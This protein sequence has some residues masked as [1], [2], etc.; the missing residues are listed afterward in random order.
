[1]FGFLYLIDLDAGF[2]DSGHAGM[3]DPVLALQWVRD[4]IKEFGGDLKH[5]LI[6]GQSGDGAKC[7][8]LT[9]RSAARGRPSSVISMRGQQLSALRREA[10]TARSLAV[11]TALN[12]PVNRIGELRPCPWSS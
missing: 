12:L 5:V 8:T 10:A 11:L 4:N 2:D 9:G 6:F 7:A 1:L 3:L